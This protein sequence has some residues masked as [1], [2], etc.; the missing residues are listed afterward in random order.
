MLKNQKSRRKKKHRIFRIRRTP[1]TPQQQRQLAKLVNSYQ[2]RA[3]RDW[4][5]FSSQVDA[6]SLNDAQLWI[7]QAANQSQHL[8][9]K[10]VR[11]QIKEYLNM[12]N[13]DAGQTENQPDSQ[14]VQQL[15][16]YEHYLEGLI[17]MLVLCR[18]FDKREKKNRDKIGYG[19]YD[20]EAFQLET[21]NAGSLSNPEEQIESN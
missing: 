12:V 17:S 6:E 16:A 4:Y 10:S 9:P 13:I 11:K 2:L 1:M 21:D 14:A 8:Y 15:V 18:R 3:M 7:L 20:D 19:S 5:S